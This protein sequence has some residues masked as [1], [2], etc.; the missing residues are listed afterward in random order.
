[1]NVLTCHQ[2]LWALP[3]ACMNTRI[4]EQLYFLLTLWIPDEFYKL[5]AP[6]E[7]VFILLFSWPLCTEQQPACSDFPVGLYQ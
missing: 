4:L 5:F 1:M 3:P 2:Y 7:K 6:L